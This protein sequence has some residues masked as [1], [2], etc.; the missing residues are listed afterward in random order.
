MSKNV[1]VM[2]EQRDGVISKVTLELLGKGRTLA[3]TLGQELVAVVLGSGIA[4]K[5]N[6]LIAYGADRVLVVDDPMLK[7][8]LTE[9][10]AAATTKVIR[11]YEPDIVLYGATSIGRDLAPRI[12][13]RVKTGLTADCTKLEIDE[14]T[15]LLAMTRPAFGGNIM[16]TIMCA[17]HRPQMATV[18]PGVMQALE[19][20]ETRTGSVEKVD[21]DLTG[22]DSKV[23]I[24]EV[25]MFKKKAADITESKMLVSAGRGI[26]SEENMQMVK[27]VAAALGAD[28]CGSRAVIDQGWLAKDL[29]IGQTGKTVRPQLYLA[30]GISGAIQHVAGMEGSEL[31]VAINKN[32]G[33][34]IFKVADLG[35]VGDLKVILPKL[36]KKLEEI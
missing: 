30:C 31:I 34:P 29:Q 27:D 5:A 3:D 20:D 33:A 15:K 36:A 17:D 28:L 4:D 32:E 16:A 14:E 11:E 12:S 9:P 2:A 24:R 26:G 19:K 7:E 8:Y 35:I 25:V 18:R 6:E 10:Y 22:C 13:A 21:V 23:K 1:F